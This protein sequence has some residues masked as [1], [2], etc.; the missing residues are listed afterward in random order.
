MHCCVHCNNGN[1][2]FRKVKSRDLQLLPV[3]ERLIA[4]RSVTAA[5]RDLNLTTPAA[6]RALSRL[7]DVFQDELLVRAGRGMVLTTKAEALRPLV[8]DCLTRVDAL[9]RAAEQT[10]IRRIQARF[11]IL[12]D[13]VLAGVLCSELFKAVDKRAPGI[14]LAITSDEKSSPDDL[15][16]GAVD[17]EIVGRTSFPPEV[18]AES[19]GESRLIGLARRG[20]PLFKKGVTLGGFLRHPHI[21]AKVQQE[22]EAAFLRELAKNGVSREVRFVAPSFYAAA[23]TVSGSDMIMTSPNVIGRII[24]SQLDLVA[25]EIP[26]ELPPIEIS[27]AWHARRQSDFAHAWVRDLVYRIL[28]KTMG[29]P[30][31]A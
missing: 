21:L 5:A 9:G 14:S 1:A 19:I 6:S 17:L 12:C 11:T 2:Q 31:P 27:V 7:R 4:T 25:F 13:D 30:A 23:N 10:D 15:R 28:R 26:L 16:S 22:Y 29:S 24:E 18:V 3:L 20:H 8:Q